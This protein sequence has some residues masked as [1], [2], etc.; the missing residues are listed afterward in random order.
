MAWIRQTAEGTT[1]KVI[2][3][4]RC[5]TNAIIGLHGDALKIKLTAPPVEGAANK[6][7]VQLLAKALKVPKSDI[8][9]VRGKQSRQKHILVRS[10]PKNQV[11]S[12]LI[13]RQ[14][15]TP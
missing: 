7:C 3:Q 6:A 4:P 2:V 1:F 14:P 5:T 13:P 11:E 12:A 15:R 10:A 9:I 8:S